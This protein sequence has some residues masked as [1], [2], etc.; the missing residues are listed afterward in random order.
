M[1]HKE[2]QKMVEVGNAKK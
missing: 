2:Q 1:N